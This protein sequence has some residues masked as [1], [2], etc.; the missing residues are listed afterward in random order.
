MVTENSICSFGFQLGTL[1]FYDP[2][3]IHFFSGGLKTIHFKG[4]K[5]FVLASAS[6]GS[7][8]LCFP[9]V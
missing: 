5:I 6:C 1:D 8:V 4:E 2:L 7:F 3:N 9:L